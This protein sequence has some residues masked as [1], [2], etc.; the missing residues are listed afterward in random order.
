MVFGR[1]LVKVHRSVPLILWHPNNGA[2]FVN[3]NVC[4]FQRR[5]RASIFDHLLVGLDFIQ[6]GPCDKNKRSDLCC[7]G[8]ATAARSSMTHRLSRVPFLSLLFTHQ[9]NCPRSPAHCRLGIHPVERR[10]VRIL[11]RG[12]GGGGVLHP[13]GGDGG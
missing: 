4:L 8:R 7:A 10:G 1:D 5:R 2:S 13:A 9:P 12:G 3:I 11:G 6:Q